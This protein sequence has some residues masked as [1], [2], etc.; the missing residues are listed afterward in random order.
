MY[1][2]LA[3]HKNL[4]YYSECQHKETG[5]VHGI[6]GFRSLAVTKQNEQDQVCHSYVTSR[7]FGNFASLKAVIFIEYATILAI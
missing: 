1:E 4:F 3:N 5:L 7:A 6:S 2:P